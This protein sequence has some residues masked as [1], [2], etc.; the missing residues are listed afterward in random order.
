MMPALQL[1]AAVSAR[2]SERS[3]RDA[4]EMP[5]WLQAL[6]AATAAAQGARQRRSP[7]TS[8][9]RS[10]GRRRRPSCRCWRRCRRRC[11]SRRPSRRPSRGCCPS[12]RAGA[13]GSPLHC[14]TPPLARSLR[15]WPSCLVRLRTG[16][17]LG[18]AAVPPCSGAARLALVAWRTSRCGRQRIGARSR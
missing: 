4:E 15:C 6:A 2:A 14:P 10:S 5:A 18:S 16:S 9:G 17:D 1:A 13:G 3:R 12:H 7:S 11:P 8:W